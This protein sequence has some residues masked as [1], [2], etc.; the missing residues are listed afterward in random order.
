MTLDFID[1]VKKTLYDSR[2]HRRG[3]K[4]LYDSR[5]HRRGRKT[6]YDSRF[7]RRGKK[8]Y[9]TLDFLDVVKNII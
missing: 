2:F 1:V 8:H 3:T 5:F 4:T 9:M 6:L 7:H